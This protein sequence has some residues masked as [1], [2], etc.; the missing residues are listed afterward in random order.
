MHSLLLNVLIP[1]LLAFVIGI[2]ITPIV[3][4]FLY[5]HR[6]WKKQGGKTA[7]G[8][9]EATE[10]NRLK[11]A[12][13]TKTPRMGGIVIW[14]SVLITLGGTYALAAIFPDS[15]FAR[16]DYL[17]RSQT[18][19]P[20]A[21]LLVGACIGFLND[22][23]DVAHDGKGLRLSI[24]LGLIT[25]LSTV[26]GWWFYFKLGVSSISI[27]FD[28][29]LELG[30]LIIPFFVLL[31]L[32]LYASGVIDGIDGLSGGVFASIFAAYTGIAVVQSQFDL[33]VFCATVVGAIMAF[34]WF[35]VPPARFWM[36]ETG[37]MA[38][39]LSLATVVFMTDTLGEGNGIVLLPIVGFPLIATVASNVLQVSYRKCTG[40]KLFRIAPLHHHFEAIGWPSYKVTM[41]YWIISLICA[42]VGVI[43]ATLA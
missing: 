20:A 26:L 9:H 27:P 16:L 17:S 42:V 32:M 6:V 10:F 35:N 38:L 3:T 18:L 39:T 33:A 2:F 21:T 41:R 22:F 37:S 28:G 7:L 5:K 24:R 34:L 4:H 25:I 36:T 14:G 1:S 13:E 31:T 8:G 23:Y 15:I 40:K 12:E 30:V 43:I 29:V 11:G 19:I